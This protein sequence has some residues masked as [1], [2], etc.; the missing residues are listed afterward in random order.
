MQIDPYYRRQ[1]CSPM[2]LVSGN[3]KRIRIF[4]GVPLDGR[5]RQMTVGLSTTAIFGD[6][7]GYFSETLEITPAIL[8]SDMLCLVGP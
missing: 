6:I 4:A 1:K 7:D 8:C 5:G 2:I 3:I